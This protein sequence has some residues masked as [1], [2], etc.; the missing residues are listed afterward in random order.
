MCKCAV[1]AFGHVDKQWKQIIDRLESRDV[2]FFVLTRCRSSRGCVTWDQHIDQWVY[3]YVQICYEYVINLSN[4]SY[5][6]VLTNASVHVWW[7]I[8]SCWHVF[9]YNQGTKINILIFEISLFAWYWPIHSGVIVCFRTWRPVTS[10]VVYWIIFSDWW[11]TV[12]VCWMQIQYMTDIDDL[13][14]Y[15]DA[16]Y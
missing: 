7:C 12:H 9:S 13:Y 14:N 5:V 11:Q 15:T 4:A 10:D 8:Y 1:V 16:R 6:L 3:E 2:T